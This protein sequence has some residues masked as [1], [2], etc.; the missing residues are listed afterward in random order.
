MQ[1]QV[2][3]AD[4][5]DDARRRCAGPPPA[6]E[7]AAPRGLEHRD[8]GL[9]GQRHRRA[10]EPAVV[11][12][13]DQLAV[14]SVDPVGGGEGHGPARGPHQVGEEANR[15]GLA[16]RAR[17][18]DH[19]DRRV[20][21]RRLGTGIHG[22]EP[23]AGFGDQPG[24]ERRSRSPIAPVSGGSAATGRA[25]ILE[26]RAERFGPE[27][28]TELADRL[29]SGEDGGVVTFVGRT[30][31]RPGTPAPGRRRRRLATPGRAVEELEYEA[32]EPLALRVL[33]EI[34]D[35]IEA[36]F[37][38]A[39][40]RSSTG[41]ASCAGR[42]VDRSWPRAHRG[43]AF[44][45]ARYAID[46]TKARAPI[47]KAERFADGHVWIGDVARTAPEDR[48]EG[49]EAAVLRAMQLVGDG[50][51][52][53]DLRAR[54]R[55][56]RRRGGRD[57]P[58]CSCSVGQERAILRLFGVNGLDRAGR[59]LA[60]EVVDGTSARIR[61]GWAAASPCRSRW[62]WP[63]TTWRPRTSRC[64]WPPA[65]WTSGWRRS[66]S[67]SRTAAPSPCQRG[68][69]RAGR[70]GTRRREPDRA[71][72]AAPA[73]RGLAAAVDRD[74]PDLAGDRRCPRRGAPGD[75]GRGRGHPRGGPAQP[76][77]RGPRRPR[78]PR[79]GG[80]AGV[81]LVARRPRRP[82]PGRR[83]GPRRRRSGRCRCC[84]GSST[85]RAR[86]AAATCA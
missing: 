37:G 80:L 58:P 76:R 81:A 21:H 2:V 39:G 22:G 24:G 17:H 38:V 28:A 16:V 79:R 71:S 9:L 46:E 14:V 47:W 45:A 34:A 25:R 6:Q 3:G 72:R 63:S 65:T 66:S 15:R 77:A 82:R 56:S 5:G 43:A 10:A 52:F 60:A 64:R 8:V 23:R 40:W 84:A 73:A 18:L 55:A 53:E 57:A 51:T 27:L 78:R 62:P 85:R 29:A 61:G 30:R 35:E 13:F 41:P 83:A 48:P 74:H 49:A 7:H 12:A 32:F 19:R 69:P 4:V 54:R 42:G 1:T 86:G 70:D 20:R 68:G 67:P 59:P 31:V 36:R 11:T 26:L 75:R 50:S 44:E 33:G